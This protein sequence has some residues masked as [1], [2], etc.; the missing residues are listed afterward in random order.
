MINP[1]TRSSSLLFSVGFGF[2]LFKGGSSQHGGLQV[3]ITV[4]TS[5]TYFQQK[6][7]IFQFIIVISLSQSLVPPL[8]HSLSIFVLLFQIPIYFS[9]TIILISFLIRHNNTI[10]NIQRFCPNPTYF[11]FFEMTNNL[12]KPHKQG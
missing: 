8:H 2:C 6:K 4:Y 7:P 10:I 11:F 3:A 12:L 5:T 1:I 9:H